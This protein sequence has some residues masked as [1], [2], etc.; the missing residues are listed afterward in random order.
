MYQNNLYAN[1][2]KMTHAKQLLSE[3]YIDACHDIDLT[4]A[5]KQKLSVVVN[6]LKGKSDAKHMKETRKKIKSSS[7]LDT[8]DKLIPT[9]EEMDKFL[10]WSLLLEFNLHWNY[11]IFNEYHSVHKAYATFKKLESEFKF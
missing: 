7:K 9:K 5:V 4:A 3:S 10:R 1:P 11:N 2:N 8:L 6:G